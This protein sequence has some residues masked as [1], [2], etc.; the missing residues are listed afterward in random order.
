MNDG[1]PCPRCGSTNTWVDRNMS[2]PEEIVCRDCNHGNDRGKGRVASA[3]LVVRT[4]A[5]RA[6]R[7]TLCVHGYTLSK[8]RHA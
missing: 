1:D 8:F 5:R 3:H 4:A 7:D 6:F 2:Y